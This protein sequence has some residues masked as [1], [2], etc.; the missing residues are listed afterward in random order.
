[1][2]VDEALELF[3]MQIR[4]SKSANTSAAYAQALRAFANTLAA[5]DVHPEK[6]EVTELLPDWLEWYLSDLQ[7]FSVATEKL[8]ATAVRSFYKFCAAQEHAAVGR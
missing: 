3:L 4:R 8:Y 5:R 2:T 1:M 7:D 6:T